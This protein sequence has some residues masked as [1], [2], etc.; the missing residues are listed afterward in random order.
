MVTVLT[1][2]PPPYNTIHFKP[3]M[4]LENSFF[5]LTKKSGPSNQLYYTIKRF[6]QKLTLTQH[7]FDKTFRTLYLDFRL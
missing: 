5:S 1:S 4:Q 7:L 6:G 3:I 2:S